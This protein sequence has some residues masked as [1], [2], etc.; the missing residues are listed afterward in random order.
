MRFDSRG[1][2]EAMKH[3]RAVLSV[4]VADIALCADDKRQPKLVI[5]VTV[6]ACYLHCAKAMMR[7]ALWD[8][9]HHVDRSIMPPMGEMLR[10]QIGG[11]APLESQAEMLARYAKDL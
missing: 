8:A 7:S 2:A 5:R 1:L 3:G 6:A 10:D 9:S 4:D 11:D